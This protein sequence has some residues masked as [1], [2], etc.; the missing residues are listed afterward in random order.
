M[1]VVDNV[2]K[3]FRSS[4]GG[5]VSAVDG[6]SFSVRDGET[7]GVVGESGC[8]KSTMARMLVGLVPPTSG[9]I[10]LDGQ[11][12]TAVRGRRDRLQLARRIQMVFQDPH[13]SLNPWLTVHDA[14]NEV[15]TVHHHNERAT[16]SRQVGE[17]LERVGLRPA[18]GA[19][20]AHELSG[21]Q[22]QRVG[23][24]RALAVNPQVLV[25]DEAVSALDSSVR[26]EIMNLLVDLKDDIGLTMVF[27]S[28]D[29]SMV[30]HISDRILVMYRGRTVEQG[31]WD[32]VSDAPAHPYTRALQAAALL[33]PGATTAHD[34]VV[35][36]DD[37]GHQA[38][39]VGCRFQERCPHTEQVCITE[40]PALLTLTPAH[41][42]R[43]HFASKFAVEDHNASGAHAGGR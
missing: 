35:K 10:V 36:S 28:H 9:R 4:A 39:L 16:R 7:L 40:E 1:L 17:L 24:A 5:H 31:P 15:L 37:S 14:L 30:R 38:E 11:D 34:E 13:S 19:R 8:G 26:A 42:S 12:I 27:I 2:M 25:L 21:G 6:V 32:V 23:I 29:L 41:Q 18:V 43:C 20:Y 33:L 22:R 3:T